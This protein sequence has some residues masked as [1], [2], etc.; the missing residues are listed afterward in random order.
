MA[1]RNYKVSLYIST[2]CSTYR[3]LSVDPN[4][5]IAKHTGR[6]L[7]TLRGIRFENY[8]DMNGFRVRTEISEPLVVRTAHQEFDIA[9]S[10]LVLSRASSGS[11][12]DKSV[13]NRIKIIICKLEA[14]RQRAKRNQKENTRIL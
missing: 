3:A 13:S 12:I 4:I 9:Q 6:D 8:S 10:Q 2:V 11:S 14:Y 1:C 5:C 7:Y